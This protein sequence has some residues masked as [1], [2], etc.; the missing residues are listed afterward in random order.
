MQYQVPGNSMVNGK[1]DTHEAS[2]SPCVRKSHM[3]Q[4]FT[5][6]LGCCSTAVGA[7]RVGGRCCSQRIVLVLCMRQEWCRTYLRSRT[8]AVAVCPVAPSYDPYKIHRG[9]LPCTH[10]S[11]Q[12]NPMYPCCCTSCVVPPYTA[13]D[14]THIPFS[15]S[16]SFPSS[17]GWVKI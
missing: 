5:L 1:M 12:C 17:G 14:G 10:A 13:Q 7:F 6:L 11:W 9:P 3:P 16:F 15:F 2:G 8:E 4:A